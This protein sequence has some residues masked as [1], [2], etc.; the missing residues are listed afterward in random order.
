MKYPHAVRLLHLCLKPWF[1]R[2]LSDWYYHADTPGYAHHPRPVPD[3]RWNILKHP[4]DM[5]QHNYYS[6]YPVPAHYVL[7]MPW[8]HAPA[9]IDSKID[10]QESGGRI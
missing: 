2:A 8:I 6:W 5:Q 7:H 10:Y 4:Q 1:P 3:Y 9:M